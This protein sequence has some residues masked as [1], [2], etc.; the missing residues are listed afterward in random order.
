V[1]EFK[2]PLHQ[3]KKKKKNYGAIL[4]RE[5]FEHNVEKGREAKSWGVGKEDLFL[6]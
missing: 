1:P 3:K 6:F 5:R 4:G 2:T